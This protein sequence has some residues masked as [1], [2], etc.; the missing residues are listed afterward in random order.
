[1]GNSA[2]RGQA[3]HA[4]PPVDGEDGSCVAASDE[5]LEAILGA[6]IGRRRGLALITGAAS[7][8]IGGFSSA[9]GFLGPPPA[10]CTMPPAPQCCQLASC[11]ECAWEGSKDQFTCPE[12]FQPTYWT[13]IDPFGDTIVCGECSRGAN[14]FAGPWAC[15][16]WY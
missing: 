6:R 16:I 14:C 13:C 10:H 8:L 5:P 12:G 7:A 1:M 2:V 15:S 3:V 11:V 9:C 4:P